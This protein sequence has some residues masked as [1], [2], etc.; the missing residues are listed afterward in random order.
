[1][2]D[3]PVLSGYMAFIRELLPHTASSL[4]IVKTLLPEQTQSGTLITF[5]RTPETGNIALSRVLLHRGTFSAFFGEYPDVSGVMVTSRVAITEND[6]Y[7]RRPQPALV[8]T[9]NVRPGA[10]DDPLIVYEPGR[11][12]YHAGRHVAQI[13]QN[14]KEGF[15]VYGVT[16]RTVPLVIRLAPGNTCY[17]DV[18]LNQKPQQI[19]VRDFVP[20]T[21][22]PI[23]FSAIEMGEQTDSFALDPQNPTKT[24]YSDTNPLMTFTQ[25]AAK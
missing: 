22:K 7:G 18:F 16:D 23:P 24:I 6:Q 25:L 3:L 19:T 1:M 10:K 13:W 9:R 20:I 4:D 17:L 14:Q 11:N 2:N 21:S 8:V 5:Y 12:M 15:A